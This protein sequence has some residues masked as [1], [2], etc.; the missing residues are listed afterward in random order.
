MPFYLCFDVRMINI[1][2]LVTQE[3]D[4]LKWLIQFIRNDCYNFSVMWLD[5][6][7]P[8]VFEVQKMKSVYCCLSPFHDRFKIYLISLIEIW[9]GRSCLVKF[10]GLTMQSRCLSIIPRVTYWAQMP[11]FL[12]LPVCPS[13]CF[14]QGLDRQV[15]RIS[16]WQQHFIVVILRSVRICA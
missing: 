2:I 14:I 12:L 7:A 5:Q 9:I 8:I 13:A 6:A 1:W 11:L 10:S 15:Q 16:R 4:W 3:R